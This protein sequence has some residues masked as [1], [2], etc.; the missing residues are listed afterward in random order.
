MT[1]SLNS[2]SVHMNVSMPVDII[3]KIDDFCNTHKIT[4]SQLIGYCFRNAMQGD[5]DLSLPTERQKH[6][7][8]VTLTVP[9]ETERWFFNRIKSYNPP[10]SKSR[11]VAAVIT[12][13]LAQLEAYLSSDPEASLAGLV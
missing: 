12:E 13:Q 7:R 11:A 1:T 2:N 6:T 8:V 5:Q 3:Y 10:V 9:A 4:K